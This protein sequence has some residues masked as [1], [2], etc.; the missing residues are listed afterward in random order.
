M[1]SFVD[2]FRGADL[3]VFDAMYSLSDAISIKADWGHSS[4]I[5]AVE[6]CQRAGVKRLCMFHHEPAY[7][8]A[9][10][11]NVLADTRRFEK[12][13]REGQALEVIAAYDG[14]ELDV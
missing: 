4:N 3:V 13:T 9:K 1:N 2:F 14:L 8:D 7:D 6:L 12:L 5:V 10:I 11:E